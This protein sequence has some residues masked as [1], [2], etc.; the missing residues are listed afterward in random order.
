MAR[1]GKD[2]ETQEELEAYLEEKRR[3]KA[4]IEGVLRRGTKILKE[5]HRVK[6]LNPGGRR[7]EV[8][9]SETQITRRVREYERLGGRVDK[10][11]GLPPRVREIALGVEKE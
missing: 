8:P 4:G 3:Q 5:G 10:L 9:L 11:I 1:G 6:D 7:R 2:W